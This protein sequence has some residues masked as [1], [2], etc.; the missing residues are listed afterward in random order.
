[1]RINVANLSDYEAPAPLGKGRYY[2]A[3]SSVNFDTTD[4]GRDFIGLT[5]EVLDGPELPDGTSPAGRRLSE[6]LYLPAADMKDGGRFCGIKL[7][8]TCEAFGLVWDETGFDA[9]EFIGLEAIAV[10]RP[11]KDN[12]EQV[13]VTRFMPADA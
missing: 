5:L 9:E 8:Q 11:R 10:V 4:N 3:C 12:P 2:V 6:R 1:M 7:R 13:E